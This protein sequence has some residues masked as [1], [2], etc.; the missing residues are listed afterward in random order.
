MNDEAEPLT[1]AE[2][3][4]SL[5]YPA[6]GTDLQPVL[7]TADRVETFVYADW[8]CSEDE[9]RQAFQNDTPGGLQLVASKA[10]PLDRY[11]RACLRTV[12]TNPRSKFF[13]QHVVGDDDAQALSELF[14]AGF[15]LSDEE[16]AAYDQRRR[17]ATGVS[18]PWVREFW[19]DYSGGSEPK[20]LKLLY[21][22]D[23][24]LARYCV[25]YHR[26]RLAPQFACTVQS[27]PGFG[28]GWTMLEQPEGAFERF[29]LACHP[30]PTVWIRGSDTGFRRGGHWDRPL[31]GFGTVNFQAFVHDPEIA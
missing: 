3:S 7:M 21:F 25:L 10:V 23:E 31:E 26:R 28:H 12:D 17:T 29:L 6:C 5:F 14:P 15:L 11:G 27:G 22:S 16:L 30:R 20:K 2:L 1:K 13:G 18:R 24:G 19:F 9:V 4:E 8:N